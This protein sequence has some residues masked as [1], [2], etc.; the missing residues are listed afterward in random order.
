MRPFVPL[1][2][3][4]AI[5]T[6]LSSCD[7]MTSK[8]GCAPNDYSG[9]FKLISATTGHN[10]LYGNDRIYDKNQLK[11][12]S[13]KGTDTIFFTHQTIILNHDSILAVDFNSRPAV[14]YMRFGN[15]DID[16]LNI[17]YA[18]LDRKCC[19][20]YQYISQFRYNNKMD[21]PGEVAP[22]ELLK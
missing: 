5:T 17:S 4:I 16:T 9:E 7:C 6:L 13:L 22:H 10:L 1:L 20:M 3:I 14:A 18:S 21:I 11:F 15:G 19:G 12:Y 8:V 2:T